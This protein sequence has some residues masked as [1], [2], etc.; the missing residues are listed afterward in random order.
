MVSC[1]FLLQTKMME[2]A[3]SPSVA[4]AGNKNLQKFPA[5]GGKKLKKDISRLW[6]DVVKQVSE[7]SVLSIGLAPELRKKCEDYNLSAHSQWFDG[8]RKCADKVKACIAAA[9]NGDFAAAR[10]K[11][12]EVNHLT[13]ECH[14]LYK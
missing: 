1:D 14:R 10:E 5:S 4:T 7:E 11:I 3:E 12:S 9:E 13:K 2:K 8:W 6:K